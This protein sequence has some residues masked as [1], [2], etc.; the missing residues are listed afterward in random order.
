M[1]STFF[2]I[3]L[4]SVLVI[5]FYSCG[6]FALRNLDKVDR[7]THSLNLSRK[8]LEFIPFEVFAVNTLTELRLFKNQLNEISPKIKQLYN[9][10]KLYLG[11]NQ[12]TFL[13]DEIGALHQLKTLSL[14]NNQLDSLPPSFANLTQLEHLILDHNQFK[15]L[16]AVIGKLPNLK[17]LSVNFNQLEELDTAIFESGSIEHLYLNNNQLTTIPEQIGKLTNLHEL[18]LNQAG[19]MLELPEAL[20][21]LRRMDL[22]EVDY[23]VQLPR[24]IFV[25][26]SPGMRLVIN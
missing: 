10:E 26:R 20:C 6:Y 23:T 15:K 8:S 7:T 1:K 17:T 18:H 2:K 3:T 13:P 22:L 14:R 5:T 19:L 4:F 11:R 12:L 25:R 16:P 9:L 24:C 21:N